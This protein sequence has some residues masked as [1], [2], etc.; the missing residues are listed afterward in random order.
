MELPHL[1]PLPEWK[2]RL[3]NIEKGEAWKWKQELEI[4]AS[5]LDGQK[6]V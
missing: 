2:D 3:Q 6:I 5:Y 4:A 1:N